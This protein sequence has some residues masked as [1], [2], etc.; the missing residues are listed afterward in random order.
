MDSIM[1]YMFSAVWL[2]Q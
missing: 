1:Q 2:E